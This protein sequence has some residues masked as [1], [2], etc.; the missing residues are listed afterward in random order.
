[1]SLADLFRPKWKH[2]KPCV[3]L[4]AIKAL[5]DQAALAE[6]AKTDSD[7]EVRDAAAKR[8]ADLP[9]AAEKLEDSEQDNA[10]VPPAVPASVATTSA[11]GRY[12]QGT[13]VAQLVCKA[14]LRAQGRLDGMAAAEY[15]D[16]IRAI[17]NTRFSKPSIEKGLQHR[18]AEVRLL[19][20]EFLDDLRKWHFIA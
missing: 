20:Q 12:G 7:P 14:I 11:K 10:K 19:V 1:M 9:R 6:I 8:L 5:T 13:N 2:S 3:R 17:C 16:I 4:D 18:N 15:I